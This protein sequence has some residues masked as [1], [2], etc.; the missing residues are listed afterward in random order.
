MDAGPSVSRPSPKQPETVTRL[1]LIDKLS[2]EK[3]EDQQ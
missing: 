2:N 3:K 1:A